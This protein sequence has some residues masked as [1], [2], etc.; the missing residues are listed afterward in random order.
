M[1]CLHW[2]HLQHETCCNWSLFWCLEAYHE[3]VNIHMS[4]QCIR[5]QTLCLFWVVQWRICMLGN[6]TVKHCS[7]YEHNQWPLCTASH[8]SQPMAFVFITTLTGSW[9]SNCL[10]LHCT[11][12]MTNPL[13]PSQTLLWQYNR[14]LQYRL[15]AAALHM[16]YTAVHG[17]SRMC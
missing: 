3:A 7:I 15:H 9:K 10:V 8:D 14:I 16:S 5:W 1:G 11:D 12:N 4:L 2:S 6:L 13:R 17:D